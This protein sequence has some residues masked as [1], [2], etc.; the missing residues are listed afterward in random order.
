M[1]IRHTRPITKEQYE[2]AQEHGG[3]LIPEDEQII[4]SDAERI[5]Y[6]IYG[7]SVHKET[8]SNT[9]ETTYYV[10]YSTGSHCD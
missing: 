5:G 2:R 8:D 7:N 3:S 6:G 4:F 9:N 1:L 10:S